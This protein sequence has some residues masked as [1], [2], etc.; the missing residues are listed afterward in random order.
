MTSTAT[1]IETDNATLLQRAEALGK[2]VGNTPLLAVRKIFSHKQVHIYAKAEWQQLSGSIKARA[3]YNIVLNAIREGHFEGNKTLL[4]ATS[5]NTGIAYATIAAALDIPIAL[6]LPENASKARK[7]ILESLGVEII[8]T[9]KFGGT[10]EAQ[11]VAQFLAQE[12]PDKYFYAD[13]YKNEHNWKAHYLHTANEIYR[14]V[15]DITHF[16]A[17]LGTTGTF[18]GTGKRLKEINAAIQLVALQP[19]T[20][21]HGLEGWKHLDTAIVPGIYDA[22]LAD[23]VIEV[24]TEEAYH[25]LKQTA[26]LE[27]WVLSPSA[28]ANLAGA[29]KLAAQLEEGVIVTVLP[30]N[31]DK[32]SEVISKL[33]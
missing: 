22:S 8:Y 3:A 17:G 10:D 20:A 29:I 19:D 33:L 28:A 9:S 16:V 32:Y 7:D 15:P 23:S 24:Q 1:Y 11:E 25:T 5:G 6:C 31:A 4:D 18:T 27:G 21:L 30:D 26:Q 12:Y 13:Q 2:Q 14:E